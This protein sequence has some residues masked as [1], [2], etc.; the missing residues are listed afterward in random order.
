MLSS[1][2]LI[3]ILTHPCLA[4]LK[5]TEQGPMQADAVPLLNELDD[6]TKRLPG[7]HTAVPTPASNLLQLWSVTFDSE[8]RTVQAAVSSCYTFGHSGGRVLGLS[9][10]PDTAYTAPPLAPFQ[11]LVPKLFREQTDP[12]DIQH[13]DTVGLLAAACA[14]G[15]LRVYA[16]PTAGAVTAAT[17]LSSSSAAGSSSSSSSTSS[18]PAV[19][20]L[21][22]QPVYTASSAGALV[23]CVDWCRTDPQLILTGMSDGSCCT[24]RLDYA[25][26]TT[27]VSTTTAVDADT[28]TSVTLPPTVRAA[29]PW[30]R[31]MDLHRDPCRPLSCAVRGVQWC[32]H[33]PQLFAAAGIGEQLT[34][35]S[36]QQ[37]EAPVSL[38]LPT[39]ATHCT[40]AVAWD[41]QNQGVFTL[42]SDDRAYAQMLVYCKLQVTALWQ[43]QT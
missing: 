2:L 14:D 7:L 29:Q 24:W 19:P 4:M 11:E 1:F 35:W 38:A 16:C 33:W 27:S 26:G 41:A 37:S 32:P 28:D 30:Q 36:T 40:T 20:V 22:L 39:L 13:A 25:I 18:S 34:V 10:A 42:A 21:D 23:T 43:P 15:V 6:S 12:T 17:T 5:T 31:F 8:D 9:W 3:L